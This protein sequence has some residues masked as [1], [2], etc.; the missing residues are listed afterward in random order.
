MHELF[1]LILFY[2]NGL[3]ISNKAIGMLFI[4]VA[5]KDKDHE[6]VTVKG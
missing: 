1:W 3:F 6:L 2:N 5:T 4:R